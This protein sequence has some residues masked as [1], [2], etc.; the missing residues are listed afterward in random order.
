MP[1]SKAVTAS[2]GTTAQ[3]NPFSGGEL[4]ASK[5]R[6]GPGHPSV[7]EAQGEKRISIFTNSWRESD[8]PI[9]ELTNGAGET[10]FT[11]SYLL[12]ANGSPVEFNRPKC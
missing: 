5:A 6:H 12:T 9:C 11:R 8:L 3:H 2:V 4:P 1:S 10:G 7:L